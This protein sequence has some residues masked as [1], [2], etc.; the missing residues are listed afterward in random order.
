MGKR[1]FAAFLGNSRVIIVNILSK[2]I[3]MFCLFSG[4]NQINCNYILQIKK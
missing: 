1:F 3:F 4:N 2:I